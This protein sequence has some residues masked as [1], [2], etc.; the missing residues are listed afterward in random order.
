MPAILDYES[1]YTPTKPKRSPQPKNPGLKRLLPSLADLVTWN[2]FVE[3]LRAYN[4]YYRYY[5]F[6]VLGET[7]SWL[8]TIRTGRDVVRRIDWTYLAQRECRILRGFT[9]M[10]DLEGNW[11]LLG[12]LSSSRQASFLLNNKNMPDVR[13][14]REQIRDL[15]EPVMLATDN[16]ADIAHTAVQEIRKVRRIEGE[17]NGVGHAAATRWLTLAHPDCLVSVNN[18]SAPNLGEVS[19]LPRNSNRLANVYSDLLLWLHDRPW[20]NEF[21][22][23]QPQEH[24][25]RIIWNCRAAVGGCI[26]V[27]KHDIIHFDIWF[28]EDP[29]IYSTTRKFF[30]FRGIF[31]QKSLTDSNWTEFRA[32][33]AFV[34]HS[35]TKHIK[36]ALSEFSKRAAVSLSVGIDA[37]GTSVEGLTGLL[38]TIQDRGD[39]WI[40][41]NAGNFT[42]H[43]KSISLQK[44]R[45][46]PNW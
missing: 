45:T 39:I 6:D 46:G 23:R 3:G 31:L 32:A 24:W 11:G 33:I 4:S 36:K 20:F 5:K 27:R 44:I 22:R 28:Y 37:G 10:D 8:H 35:G 17:R 13:S 25:E 43:P 15:I 14:D 21:N 40:F 12:D 7:H 30:S 41:H 18:A 42:F 34:K 26:Y 19:G 2:D 38:D 29:T 16:I 1:N 9:A